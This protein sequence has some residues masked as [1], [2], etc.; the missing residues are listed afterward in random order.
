M[1]S[2]N[3]SNNNEKDFPSSRS[4]NKK[5]KSF[6]NRMSLITNNLE[7]KIINS[8]DY[9][10]TDNTDNNNNFD[11]NN[12]TEINNNDGNPLLVSLINSDYSLPETPNTTTTSTSN[13]DTDIEIN[14]QQQ[15]IN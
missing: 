10:N 15:Q 13:D 12:N 3:N 9:N 14:Q 8:D 1:N 7:N 11:L 4:Y 2:I 5:K 6:S